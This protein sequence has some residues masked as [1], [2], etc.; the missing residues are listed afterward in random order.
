MGKLDGKVAIVTGSGQGIGR[1]VAIA[2]AKEGAKLV[3]AEL[4]AETG[5]AVAEEIRALG[6]EAIDVVCDVSDRQQVAEMVQRAVDEFAQIDI[7]V[8]NA[9]QLFLEYEAIEDMREERW[10]RTFETG[11]MGTWYCS[12]AVF[13][14]M[15]DQ[16]GKIINF[17]SGWG[18][19]GAEGWSDYSA[20][21]EAIRAL[22]RSAAREWGKHKITV[23]VIC[24][25]LRSPSTDAFLQRESESATESSTGSTE[26]AIDNVGGNNGALGYFGDPEIDGGPVAVFLASSDSDYMTGQTLHVDGGV[27]ITA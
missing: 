7:L 14:H 6:A 13:P 3:I 27:I 12:R 19:L 1:G 20:C 2:L 24:P 26:A 10:A 22:S 16:G 9:Q 17:G 18:I 23:N 8:N 11:L 21:K 4:N 15:K 25:G 5:R